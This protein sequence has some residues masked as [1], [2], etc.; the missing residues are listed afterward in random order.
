M[1]YRC[2]PLSRLLLALLGLIGLGG[3]VERRMV[4][5]T[6]PPYATVFDEKNQ[7]IGASPVDRTF[8][9]YG[10]YRFRLV[11][12]GCATLIVEERVR[13]P[14]YEYFPLDFIAENLIPFTLRDV[15]YFKYTLQPA[16]VVTPEA[17]LQQG[18]QLRE[19]GKTIGTPAPA[20]VQPA[21]VAPPVTFGPPDAVNPP[22]LPA[23]PPPAQP[24]V[25]AAAPQ[26]RPGTVTPVP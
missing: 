26:W 25:P 13:P 12:D 24:P 5:I 11:K 10:K 15:R 23:G 14:W 18:E 20:T 21:A 4:I 17:V 19:R 9:Y 1:P 2:V 22:P 16:P 3:C 8:V 7:I 6:D